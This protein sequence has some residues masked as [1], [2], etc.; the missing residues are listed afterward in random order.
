MLPPT[1]FF[2]YV[3]TAARSVTD[4]LYRTSDDPQ[5]NWIM[6]IGLTVTIVAAVVITILTSR[7]IQH[8]LK[9]LK[10]QGELALSQRD[11]DLEMVRR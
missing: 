11:V 7:A 3:G 4:V 5:R 8:E 1:A 2:C 10:R 6:Y 9:I